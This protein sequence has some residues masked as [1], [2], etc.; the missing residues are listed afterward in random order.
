VSSLK[1]ETSYKRGALVEAPLALPTN[2]RL[3][4]GRLDL[5][6]V[7]P[8]CLSSET[9]WLIDSSL[10]WCDPEA[11]LRCLLSEELDLLLAV[12]LLVVLAPL[13]TYC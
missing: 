12:S 6:S 4:R 3:V 10:G 1:L 2:K 13:S 9:S 5:P 11:E 8:S 7:E